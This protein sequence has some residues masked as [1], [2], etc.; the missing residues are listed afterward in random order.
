LL[1]LAVVITCAPSY[2]AI[3]V[4]TWPTPP[5]RREPGRGRPRSRRRG[6]ATPSARRWAERRRASSGF[7]PIA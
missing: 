5:P 3:W 1:P 4:A 2:F 7:S 6:P